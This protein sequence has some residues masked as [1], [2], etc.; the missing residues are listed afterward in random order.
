[1]TIGEAAAR[2]GVSI[3]TLR[4]YDKIGLVRPAA[5]TV[6]RHRRYSEEDAAW[7]E[8]VQYLRKTAMPL[9]EIARYV[10]LEK[11][12]DVTLPLRLEMLDKLCADVKARV[13]ELNEVLAAIDREGPLV[14]PRRPE[15][16][17]A[18]AR[19]PLACGGPG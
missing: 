1:M 17:Q 3:H 12:G 6:S 10:E 13:H 7:I 4:Y 15:A 9:A 8:L 18:S 14:R 16:A 19:T 5:R 2:T 11:R